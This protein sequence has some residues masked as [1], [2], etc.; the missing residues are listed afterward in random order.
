[1]EPKVIFLDAVGTLFGVQGS[2]GEI[3]RQIA[4][5]FGVDAP[6]EALN[7][8]FF[9]SFKASQSL[10][11]PEA[12]APE[13][14][15]LEFQW[16]QAIAQETFTIVGVAEQFGNFTAFFADLYAHFATAEPWYV[17]PDVL[18]A[19]K[20]WQQKEIT[21]GIIS[22]FD[23]RLYGVLKALDLHDFF[24]SITISSQARAAKPRSEIFQAALAQHNCQAT[25]VLHIGDSLK[26]DYYG[27]KAA[28]IRPFL[29]RR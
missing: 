12:K 24:T 6:A 1:M 11:F 16:W 7:K 22:N 17:Y 27:A 15:E 10:E 21:L 3:Y 23:S 29:L 9:Q 20:Q 8:A 13:I 18:P 4:L 5:D 14:F 28:G 19:L 2:V 25:E 26:E